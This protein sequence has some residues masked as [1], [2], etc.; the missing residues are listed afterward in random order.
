MLPWLAQARIAEAMDPRIGVVTTTWMSCEAGAVPAG[1]A[2]PAG[3]P[4]LH[5]LRPSTTR[6]AEHRAMHRGA[7]IPAR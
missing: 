2:D 3:L 4:A 7:R 1:D 5:A 6:V